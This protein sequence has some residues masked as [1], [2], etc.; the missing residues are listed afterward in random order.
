[1]EVPEQSIP[2]YIFQGLHDHQTDYF[3]AK[4]YFDNLKAPEKKFYTFSSS[5]HAPHLEE[6]DLFENIVRRDV[7]VQQ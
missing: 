2:V 5:A 4:S 6:Y 1:M 3:L 7:L